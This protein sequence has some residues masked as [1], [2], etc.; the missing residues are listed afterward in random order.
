LFDQLYAYY[1][2]LRESGMGRSA[3]SSLLE[4]PEPAVR[5]ISATHSLPWDSERATAVLEELEQ[6]P[7]LHAVSAKWTLREYRRGRLNLD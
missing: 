7:G 2:E 5:L 1:R 3:I 6:Q 4:D